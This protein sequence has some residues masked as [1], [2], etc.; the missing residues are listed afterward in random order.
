MSITQ[1]AYELLRW[2]VD[3]GVDEAIGEIPVDRYAAA[4]RAAAPVRPASPPPTFHPETA[5][6]P[7]IGRGTLEQRAPEQ[8]SNAAH[9]AA[10]CKSLD[11]LYAAIDSFEA[12][13]LKMTARRTVFGDGNPKAQVMLVGEAPGADED[14]IGRPFVGVS[15][16]LLDRMLASIGLDRSTCYITNILPW[17]PPGNRK[18]SLPEVE[19]MLPFVERHVELVDPAVML[20]L[21]GA[22]AS[23]LLARNEPI[24]RLRGR[25][26]D[27]ATPGLQRPVAALATFHPAFL[28]RTPGQKRE[29]W[30]DFVTL[31]QK[32][33][34][35]NIF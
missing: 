29:A 14:R 9:L 17:R 7:E 23:A 1:S 25:W 35:L 2:Y 13:P 22:A 30:R 33:D 21:G 4:A 32:I 31:R 3:A 26:F 27:Y 28:L 11:E 24:S 19:M 20:L 5:P 8:R 15:G 6:R 18:P 10:E 12:C 16:Q 34:F